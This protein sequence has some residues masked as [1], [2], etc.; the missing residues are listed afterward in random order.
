M[1]VIHA[2]RWREA[3][4]MEVQGHSWLHRELEAILVYAE[5]LS[6]RGKGKKKE[7]LI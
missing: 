2:L 3:G 5:I 4:G 1:P 6:Q 7:M